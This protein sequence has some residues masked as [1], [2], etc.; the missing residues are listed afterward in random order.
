MNRIPRDPSIDALNIETLVREAIAEGLASRGYTLA[1]AGAPVDFRVHY[2]IG[3]GQAI[4]QDSVK[5]YASLSL[6]LGP[7]NLAAVQILCRGFFMVCRIPQV[8]RA[9]SPIDRMLGG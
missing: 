5:S 1:P 3:L 6:T 2:Q 8:R 9:T 4:R 7:A